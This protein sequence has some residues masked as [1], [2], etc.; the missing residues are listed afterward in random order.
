[1]EHPQRENKLM[2]KE[3]WFLLLI[4]ALSTNVFAELKVGDN[5][6]EA[7]LYGLNT[8]STKLSTFIGKPI[9]I[10]FWASWCGPC[11]AE[12]QSLNNIAN[13]K[14]FTI[15]GVSTD[16]DSS[17]AIKLIKKQQLKFKNYIDNKMTLEKEF[18]ANTMPL[19]ILINGKGELVNVIRG[20]K[21]WDSEKNMK[22]IGKIY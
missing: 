13:N 6:Q 10:N 19:T 11:I 8:P 14:H 7:T 20:S 12:M 22:L 18:G 17:A 2:I 1:M 15:I 4:L 16:D 9:I 21:Q 5:I 3:T